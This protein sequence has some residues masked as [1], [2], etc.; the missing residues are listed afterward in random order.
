ML[1]H[2]QR[3]AVVVTELVLTGPTALAARMAALL[4]SL[5]DPNQRAGHRHSDPH[6][7]AVTRVLDVVDSAQEVA[8]VHAL[9]LL[10][11]QCIQRRVSIGLAL[12]A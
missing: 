4:S 2:V 10:P 9:W 11:G 3:F 6:F 5:A 8:I 7:L 1:E 12:A